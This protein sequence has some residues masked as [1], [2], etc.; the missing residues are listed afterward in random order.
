MLL[1]T[2]QRTH[3]A[4]AGAPKIHGR[5]ADH[6]LDSKKLSRGSVLP[7]WGFCLLDMVCWVLRVTAVITNRQCTTP[8][9]SQR[10]CSYFIL[11]RK[12]W[13]ERECNLHLLYNLIQ[14]TFH[15]SAYMP[16]IQTKQPKKQYGVGLQSLLAHFL[17]QIESGHVRTPLCAPRPMHWNSETQAVEEYFW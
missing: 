4:T 13:F 9:G 5:N 6:Q 14:Q 11:R 7:Y 17:R 16:S 15:L 10:D 8:L 3:R 1:P 12:A 2:D